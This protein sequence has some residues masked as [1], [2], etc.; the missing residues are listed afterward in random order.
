[1]FLC[2]NTLTSITTLSGAAAAQQ[3]AA[4]AQQ[5]AA[6]AQQGAAAVASSR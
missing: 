3:G 4:A 2:L 5:G 6:A 1:M